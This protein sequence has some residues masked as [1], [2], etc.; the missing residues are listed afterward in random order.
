MAEKT[1]KYLIS[2][3]EGK[4]MEYLWEQ[5]EGKLF[6]EIMDYLSNK[7]GKNWKKQTVNTF[8]KRLSDK[9]LICSKNGKNS[10]IGKLYYPALSY[11]EYKQGEAKDILDELYQGSVYRFI[12]ALSG[13][14]KL[15]QDTADTL[16]KILEEE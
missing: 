16:K 14:H 13:G 2:E 12:S 1:V 15:D 10:K 8:I 9:G 11:A 4:I 6:S 7:C 3:S 5:N